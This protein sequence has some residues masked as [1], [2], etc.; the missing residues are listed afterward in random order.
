MRVLEMSAETEKAGNVG[1]AFFY[2]VKA[3]L[4]TDWLENREPITV[5]TRVLLPWL[6]LFVAWLLPWLLPFASAFI[7]LAR[8]SCSLFV[9]LVCLF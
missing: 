4:V 3:I 5:C 2:I 1:Y 9:M 6:C 8:L 7:F